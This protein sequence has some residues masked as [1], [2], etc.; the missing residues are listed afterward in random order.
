MK[1]LI[2]A[3]SALFLST[4]NTYA[5][6]YVGV[7]A[8]RTYLSIDNKPNL[9]LNNSQDS[10]YYDKSTYNPSIFAGTELMK[11]LDAELN[12]SY[13]KFSKDNNNTGY[14]S[15]ITN[16]PLSTKFETRVSNLGLDLKP[17]YEYKN[18]SV[19]GI[20]GLNLIRI[21]AKENTS[22]GGINYQNSQTQDR[23]G[24]SLGA[25]IQYTLTENIAAR[26]QG[27]YTRV[28]TDFNK[29]DYLK[30]VNDFRTVSVGLAYLF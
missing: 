9:L 18:F 17:K 2:I 3:L 28:D 30:S 20:A 27:K 5:K 14:I 21:S 13:A 19:Y 10:N 16:S 4:S 29:L 26:I 6:N 11:N 12:F 15:A 25:G 24:Y 22:S 8:Q 1:K 23:L 7:E